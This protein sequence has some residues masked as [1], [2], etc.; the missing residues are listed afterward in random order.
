MKK[1]IF[2]VIVVLISFYGYAFAAEN[3]IY[4][5]TRSSE[6]SVPYVNVGRYMLFQGEYEQVDLAEGKMQRV[7][8]LFKIDTI[9][10]KVWRA[11]SVTV[12]VNSKVV[13]RRY[14]EPFE[15]D[16]ETTET[17]IKKK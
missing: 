8:D 15:T 12:R 4:M 9:T 7:N 5:D 13:Q 2:F 17:T 3:L 10:G 6:K 11:V 14:W 16:A 1:T